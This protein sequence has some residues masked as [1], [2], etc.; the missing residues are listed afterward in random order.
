MTD[1]WI[2][3]LYERYRQRFGDPDTPVATDDRSPRGEDA[4]QS[5]PP[6]RC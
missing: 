6:S 5:P 3:T 2:A 4:P 1:H